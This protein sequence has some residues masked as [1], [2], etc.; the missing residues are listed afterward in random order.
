MSWY[1]NEEEK[2]R[3]EPVEHGQG[4]ES[5]FDTLISALMA[6]MM[7]KVLERVMYGQ[8]EIRSS[9]GTITVELPPDLYEILDKVSD[10]EDKLGKILQYTVTT[11]V[12]KI[13][14][15]PFDNVDV[16]IRADESVVIVQETVVANIAVTENVNISVESS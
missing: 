6:L 16:S 5:M 1:S 15:L 3:S 4:N 12:Y 7:I 14:G 9:T 11:T 2:E 13:V 10:L 8:E